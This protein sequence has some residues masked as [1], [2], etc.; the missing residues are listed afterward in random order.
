MPIEGPTRYELALNRN[1]A[2][3]IGLALPQAFLQKVDRVIA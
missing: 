1:A 2:N 3:A